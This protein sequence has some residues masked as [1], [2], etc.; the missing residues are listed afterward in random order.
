MML[1]TIR[2]SVTLMIDRAYGESGFCEVNACE[3][4]E[5]A[6]L[7]GVAVNGADEAG[8]F[9]RWKWSP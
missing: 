9:G 5:P 3:L 8:D 7:A 4:D 2:E 6:G 1:K